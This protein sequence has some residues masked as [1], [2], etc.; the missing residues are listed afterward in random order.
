[1]DT[2]DIIVTYL[3]DWRIHAGLTQEEVGAKVGF[4]GAQVSRIERG[5]RTCDLLYL[6]QFQTVVGCKHYADPLIGPPNPD[7]A[8]DDPDLQRRWRELVNDI[9]ERL[10]VKRAAK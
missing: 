7:A 10:A 1:M 8:Y 4:T 2:E 9:A 3:K 6:R 5:K